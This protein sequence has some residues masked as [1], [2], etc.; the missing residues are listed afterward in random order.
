[1][2]F[3]IGALS[4]GVRGVAGLSLLQVCLVLRVSIGPSA[5]T[6]LRLQLVVKAVGGEEHCPEG[7]SQLIFVEVI[8]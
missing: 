3:I 8:T 5:T 7:G 2:E 6:K 4:G 1:M